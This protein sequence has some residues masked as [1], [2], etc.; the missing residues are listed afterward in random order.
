MLK[1]LQEASRYDEALHRHPALQAMGKGL[2]TQIQRFRQII[3]HALLAGPQKASIRDGLLHQIQAARLLARHDQTAFALRKLQKQRK[4]ARTFGCFHLEAEILDFLDQFPAARGAALD[5]LR[6]ELRAHLHTLEA[7]QD[8]SR[9]LLALLRKG[10]RPRESATIKRVAEISTHAAVIEGLQHPHSLIQRIAMDI[11]GLG[12][13]VRREGPP[14]LRHYEVLIRIWEADPTWIREYPG[15]YLQHFRHYQLAVHF[16]TRNPEVLEGYQDRLKGKQIFP[17]AF[18]LEYDR[19]R[20]NHLLS[21]GLNTGKLET[22]YAE[23]PRLRT[24]LE[25]AGDRLLPGT[26]LALLYNATIALF[27][28]EQFR[29]AYTMLRRLLEHPARDARLDLRDFGR[30]LQLIL[31]YELGEDELNQYLARSTSA[32]FKRHPRHWQFESAVARFIKAC[33]AG[34]PDGTR[35]AKIA[36]LTSVL[37]DLQA[38]TDAEFPLAGLN[39]VRWWL[40]GMAQGKGLS[41]VYRELI[42]AARRAVLDAER[43]AK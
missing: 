2:P 3:V 23:M 25:A 19:I 5:G 17:E 39:E 11:H 42:A 43:N 34:T 36:E 4:V 33:P 6:I 41:Q 1:I 15:L 24:W 27:V 26:H 13:I 31:L 9:E 38:Q 28:G 37:D 35:E 10:M 12:G 18:Q 16:G 21:V 29:E 22:I 14:V 32:Y 40:S 30:V 8:L 7:V 20:F